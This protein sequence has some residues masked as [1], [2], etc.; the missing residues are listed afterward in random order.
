MDCQ[1]PPVQVWNT[2]NEI[3]LRVWARTTFSENP[4]CPLDYCSPD[5][6]W[7][8]QTGGSQLFIAC[9][10]GAVSRPKKLLMKELHLQFVQM[11]EEVRMNNNHGRKMLINEKHHRHDLKLLEVIFKLRKH[12]SVYQISSLSPCGPRGLLSTSF[13][14][15]SFP[16]SES[17]VDSWEWSRGS[18]RG[19]RVLCNSWCQARMLL[20]CLVELR[21]TNNSSYV[22]TTLEHMW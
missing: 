22:N 7:F 16:L 4:K 11:K 20:R 17:T 19:L 3:I 9:L 8:W 15:F 21:I 10:V 2:T 12:Q 5:K 18:R 14:Q 1:T 6:H 13:L